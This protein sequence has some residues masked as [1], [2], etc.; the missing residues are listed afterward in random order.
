MSDNLVF[1]SIWSSAVRLIPG[2]WYF[3][4]FED[5]QV[6]LALMEGWSDGTP[7]FA[8]LTDGLVDADGSDYG[9]P[10]DHELGEVARRA[11]AI[12]GETMD[13]LRSR[14]DGDPRPS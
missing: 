9:R 3:V 4:Q 5:G 7:Q 13:P 11:A 2:R 6:C 12:L 1:N 14:Q 8:L 10:H